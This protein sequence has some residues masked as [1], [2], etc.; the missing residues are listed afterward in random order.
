MPD[1][2]PLYIVGA[3]HLG[4]ELESFLDS[5]PYELRNYEVKGFLHSYT[6]LSPLAGHP[7]DYKI[8]GTWEN[9]PLTKTDYCLIAVA[10]VGWREK[11]FEYL[12]HKTTIYTFIHPT[13]FI[14]KF[15]QIGPGSIISAHALVTTNVAIGKCV[16]INC[17]S[18]IGHDVKIGDYSS[19]MSQVEIGG[20]CTIGEKVFIGSNAVII[21]K[22][23]VEDNC[24]IGAGS[25]AIKKVKA[26]TTVFGNPALRVG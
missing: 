22:M 12:Q 16:F 18:Q 7:S 26:G 15:N 20:N 8:L 23:T 10:D 4:R 11:L 17:G 2:K 9:F 25:V 3:S 24:T 14:G 5:V 19:V 13:A 1:K 21:P 6:G